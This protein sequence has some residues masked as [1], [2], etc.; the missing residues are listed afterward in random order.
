MQRECKEDESLL[1]STIKAQNL[2]GRE[3]SHSRDASM[4][5]LVNYYLPI[6]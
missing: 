3:F 2:K 1:F 6:S 4:T 5:D